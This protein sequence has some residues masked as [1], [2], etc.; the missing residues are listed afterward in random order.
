[1][2]S[3]IV[4]EK[5]INFFKFI[6]LKLDLDENNLKKLLIYFLRQRSS[7]NQIKDIINNFDE[8]EKL[9]SLKNLS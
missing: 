7:S 6:K 5:I 4:N 8:V 3:K 1:M 9:K 2:N